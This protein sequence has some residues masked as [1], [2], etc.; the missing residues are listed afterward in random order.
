MKS[1]EAIHRGLVV[2]PAAAILMMV[3]LPFSVSAAET[4]ASEKKVVR[5]GLFEDTYHKVNEKGELYGYGYEYLQNIAGDN[6]WTMEYVD[7][8]WYTCFDKLENGEIDILNGISYTKDREK[9]MLFSTLPMAEERY[10]IYVDTRN[11]SISPSDITSVNGKT[12]GVMEDAIPEEVLNAWEADNN[13]HTTHTNITTEEDVLRNLETGKMDCFVSVE[14]IWDQDYIMPVTYIGSSSVYFAVNQ[15]RPDLKQ[16]LDNA[17]SRIINDNPF[18]NDKLYEEYFSAP[19]A[20]ILTEDE[21]AWLSEHGTIRMGYF[22]DDNLSEIDPNTGELTGVISDYIAYARDCLGEQTLN[23]ETKSYASAEELVAALQNGEIDTIFKVPH[24]VYYASEHDMS[25][26]DTMMEIPYAAVTMSDA[27]DQNKEHTAAVARDDWMQKWYIDHSYPDWKIVEYDSAG[28]ARKA[29]KK[30]EADCF[31]ERT[32]RARRYIRDSRYQVAMLKHDAEVSFGIARSNPILLSILNKTIKTMPDDM[33]TDKLSVY[34]NESET[35]TLVE[36]VK[37]NFLQV[38]LGFLLSF[39]VFTV[40]FLAWKRS[41]RAEKRLEAYQKELKLQL[42]VINAI[43]SE[44]R[45]LYLV[46]GTTGH[47]KVFK[48]DGSAMIQSALEKSLHHEKFDD[49]IR[50]YILHYVAEEDR[51]Y[52]LEH[53]E[54]R[55][56]FTE[57]PETGI[58]SLSYDRIVGDERKHW[59]ANTAK[60][61]AADGK[62]YIV[63]GFRDVHD[64]VEKQ[65]TQE[66]ALKDAL[67]VARHANRAKTSFLNNMSH[68]IR[69]PMNAIIGFTALAESHIDNKE[70]VQDYLQKIHTSGTHLLSLINEILDMS[71]IESGTVKLEEN[72]VHIPDVL[73]DLRTIIHGHVTAKQQSLYIDSLDVVH[74]DVV[75]DR[76]RIS[77]VLL[78]IVG[79]AVKYTGNGGNISVRVTEKPSSM[80]GYASYEFSIRDNG[81]GMAPEFV[82]HV[83][84]AF[85]RA[86]TSTVSGIQGTGLGMSITKNIVDLMNGTIEVK[87]ELGVGSEFIVTVDLKLVENL[88]DNMPI[89]ELQGAR[90][91]VVDDDMNTCQSV[92][93]MLRSIDMRPDWSTSGKEAVVRARESSE[94]KDEYKAYIIDYMM[95][96]MNGIETVRQIR[97]VIGDEIPIIVLTAYEWSDFE[98]EAREAGVTDFV[99]KPLFMSELRSVLSRRGKD[100]SADPDAEPVYDYSGKHVLL[101]EDN[102]LNREI[103]TFILRDAGMTV[104][105]AED[106]IEAVEIMHRAAEDQYDLIFMDIQM[107]KMDGYTATQEIRTLKNNR[108]ANIPIVAMTANAFEEDRR[109]SF[110]AGM[111]GHIA[112]PISMEAIAKV[113]DGIF[114][115]R[116]RSEH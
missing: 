45:S 15:E 44:Y 71:R 62:E 16:E 2:C 83:F 87:S 68:D 100:P 25:L 1:K 112:K 55:N 88:V 73:H 97:K 76:L 58:H 34:D 26:S 13:L 21:K 33:L 98:E 35:V 67:A 4:G 69:T 91:L 11:M 109:K 70:Q 78:N 79:N 18:Y 80:Q 66:N 93:K 47:W 38:V 51:E 103:A 29:V 7:A 39:T 104:D 41:R 101:V 3:C 50:A 116:Q 14:E 24:N 46:D 20:A 56:L 105:T 61:K 85:A 40:L 81:M 111:N 108:K 49:A 5:I 75:T 43:G 10:Y 23:F 96:D 74:E 99:S 48:T 94:I 113:L 30:G 115:R 60:F 65:I 82:E 52:C 89:P 53:T 28:A 63:L 77:Q 92:S 72:V 95:P 42:Q 8:D 107:P 32:G 86:Q 17:M 57:T 106:G 31:L 110:E 36:F 90:A 19:T 12:V 102:E 64:I 84:D 6:G 9:D 54:L 27:F 22:D 59:Q 37:D 114:D